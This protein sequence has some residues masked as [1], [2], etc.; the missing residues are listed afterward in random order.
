MN[1][2]ESKNILADLIAIPTVSSNSNLAMIEFIANYLNGLNAKV[3]IW[4]LY[5]WLTNP[6][7]GKY[8]PH[9]KGR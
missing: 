5:I 4:E 7:R 8:H 1:V 2:A 9:K 3:K 6:Y